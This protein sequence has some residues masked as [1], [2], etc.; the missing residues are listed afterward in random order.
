MH[1][2]LL[3]CGLCMLFVVCGCLRVVV[4]C[5]LFLRVYVAGR[6]FVIVSLA[7]FCIR[8]GANVPVRVRVCERGL[9]RW[10]CWLYVV[11]V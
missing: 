6:V 10:F 5:M 7:V 2:W 1:R 8:V 11:C 3:A 9:V 4:T